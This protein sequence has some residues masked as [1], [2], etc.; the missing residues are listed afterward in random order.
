MVTQIAKVLDCFRE[1]LSIEEMLSIPFTGYVGH[2]TGATRSGVSSSAVLE[3]F[4][5][6]YPSYIEAFRTIE[7]LLN[8][9]L[10][11]ISMKLTLPGRI[12]AVPL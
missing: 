7:A 11:S 3:L 4:P 12:G 10:L 6:E 8:V 1:G 5:A 2:G 9:V